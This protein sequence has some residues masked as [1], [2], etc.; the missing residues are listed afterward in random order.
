MRYN[1]ALAFAVRDLVNKGVINMTARDI[2]KKF[3]GNTPYTT[4]HVVIVR[5]KL[6]QVRRK[7]QTEHGI[8]S[9]LVNDKFFGCFPDCKKNGAGPAGLNEAYQYLAGG[10]YRSRAEGLHI[11]QSQNDPLARAAI[12]RGLNKGA[13]M[14]RQKIDEA[15]DGVSKQN[16][17]Q[18]SAE[19]M[20][21][22][23]RKDSVPSKLPAPYR[24]MLLGPAD[25]K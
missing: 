13:G 4:D 14:L 15:V 20:F 10:G 8:Q 12:K 18:K 23:V 24:P 17:A 22:Q 21:K 25:K 6:S 9:T 16:I 3:S 7:L 5:A 2:L 1:E 19:A 11:W